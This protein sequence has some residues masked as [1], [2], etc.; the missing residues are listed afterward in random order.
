MRPSPG[1]LAGLF[2][3]APR[4]VARL[5]GESAETWAALLDRAEDIA[6]SM[7]EA[8]QIEL[9]DAHPRIGADPGSVSELSFREQGYERETGTADLQ[10]RLDRLNDE[11][12]RRHG[13]RFVIFVNGRS[14][15]EIA[16]LMA[17]HMEVP[18]EDEKER[19]LRDVIAIAH[20]RLATMT[21]EEVG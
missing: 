18:R 1:S 10:S 5:S 16:D 2:E 3:G 20:S 19:G 21:L 14:R 9:L 15:A 7:P 17:R 4:F 13:F 12:E 6:L 11:Y 8:E